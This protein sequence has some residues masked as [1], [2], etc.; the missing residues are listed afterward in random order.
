MKSLLE[1]IVKSLV[2]NPE[3][4]KI[5][6]CEGKKTTLY[7]IEIDKEDIGKV[8]G[9]DGTTLDAINTLLSV[10]SVK[11]NRKSVLEIID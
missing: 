7:E 10:S 4:V 3:K 5:H 11:N 2:D 8:I 6:V 9:K 1:Y